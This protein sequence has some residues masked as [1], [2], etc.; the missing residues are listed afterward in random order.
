MGVEELITITQRGSETLTPVTW[1][2]PAA[3]VDVPV[4]LVDWVDCPTMDSVKIRKGKI[5]E[6]NNIAKE[7]RMGS[8][9]SN[10]RLVAGSSDHRIINMD[11]D[12][13]AKNVRNLEY[14]M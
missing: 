3:E 1:G 2:K 14:S 6:G 13:A 8:N 5:K 10:K 4:E 9:S 11:T 12:L 7:D